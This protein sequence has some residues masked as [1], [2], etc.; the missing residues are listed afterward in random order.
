MKTFDIEFEV[1]Q[2]FL[3]SMGVEAET[4]EQAIEIAQDIDFDRHEAED[5]C[6]LESEDDLTTI[7]VTGEWIK[8]DKGSSLKRFDIPIKA[9]PTIFQKY[10]DHAGNSCP[11]CDSPNITGNSFNADDMIAW[12]YVD[13]KK[14]QR[15][16][17]EEFNMTNIIEV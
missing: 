17:K 13:C 16:W 10:K 14:C 2:R 12:R 9:K 1:N 3:Y 4:P 15:S 6:M 11:F 7:K 5:D 8:H